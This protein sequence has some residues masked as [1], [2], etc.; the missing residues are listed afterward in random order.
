MT[1]P[2]AAPHE[3]GDLDLLEVA[4]QAGHPVADA[5]AV[6][7]ELLLAGAA[8]ADAAAQTR[9]MAVAAGQPRQEVLEL[10]EL[11]LRARFPGARVQ[12]EDVED[13]AGPVQHP[14]AVAPGLLEVAHLS[15]RELVVEDHER[16]ALAAGGR[17]DLL[18][19]ALADVGRRVGSGAFL[20][21]PGNDLA[22]RRVDEPLELVEVI[23]GHASRESLRRHADDQDSLADGLRH[24]RPL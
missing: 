16:R 14:D 23:L 12:R 21:E 10:R 24:P 8:S 5:P 7:L 3:P 2:A 20:D 22:A 4:T 19:G 9:E 18:D 1:L 15:R 17:A 6:E 13:Q 11:D